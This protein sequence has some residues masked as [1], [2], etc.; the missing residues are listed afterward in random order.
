VEDGCGIGIGGFGLW[1]MWVAG[2]VGRGGIENGKDDTRRGERRGNGFVERNGG[3]MH[4][5]WRIS[6]REQVD[7]KYIVDSGGS[8]LFDLGVGRRDEERMC[9]VPLGSQKSGRVLLLAYGEEEQGEAGR[10]PF[11]EVVELLHFVC[12]VIDGVSMDQPQGT[13][14]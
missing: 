1:R 13:N 5:S 8:E 11:F 10:K 9:R 3:T 6:G 7:D 14:C 12:G 2:I 4:I